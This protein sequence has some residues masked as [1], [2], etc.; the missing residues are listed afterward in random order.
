MQ[1][2]SKQP[3]AT[4]SLDLDN[5]WSY[6][7][8]HGDPGWEALPSYLDIVVPK[9]LDVLATLRVKITVFVV[10]QDAAIATNRGALSQIVE[11]GHEIGNHS[12]HHEP[13]LHLYSEQ[14][15][16]AEL[17][18]AERALSE[19]S[20]KIPV[21]F[22][23]PGFSHSPTL[24][25]MLSERGYQYD[26][27]SLP[28]FLGPLARAYYFFTAKLSPE[29][30][31]RRRLLF[32]SWTEGLSPLG[33]YRHT[34]GGGK[35]LEIPVTTLPVVRTPI[36]LSY[37][38]YLALFSPTLA[39]W[40]FRFALFALRLARVSPSILLHPLD[41]LTLE[42]S[43]RLAFFPAMRL[44]GR[45]KSEVM[46]KCLSLLA[47]DFR[48]LPMGEYTTLVANQFQAA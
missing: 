5:L 19:L 24:I 14:Q 2:S 39:V 37:V 15:L 25:R 4:L 29:E 28:T 3:L 27:S 35:L 23:G 41:F 34:E 47:R 7:K 13:W 21:G 20:G 22:R 31:K 38:L 17:D 45:T 10:G 6:M 33:P 1:E 30:R 48:V 36:H 16:A 44:D 42:D 46:K 8:T 40:Y 43:P 9:F 11:A 12:F 32:G 18:A 26:G